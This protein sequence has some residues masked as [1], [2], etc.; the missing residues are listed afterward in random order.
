MGEALSEYEIH[1]IRHAVNTVR[2]RNNN[3][4]NDPDPLAPLQ[5]DF[6]FW[7]LVGPDRVVVVDTGMD[8][9][10]AAA[11][12]HRQTLSPPEALRALG[13]WPDAVETVILTHA[14]YDHVGYLHAFPRAE[15]WMQ[16]AEMDFVTGDWMRMPYFAHAYETD[17]I[18]ALQKLADADRL[19][20][21][22]REVD[23]APGISLHWVGGHTAGQEVVR[24]HTARGWVVLASDA[25]HYYEELERGVPFAIA[26]SLPDML[27][28]HDRLRE[29]AET[30][31]HIVPG[32][33][34]VVAR[35]YPPA[36]RDLAENVFRV[37]LPP[38]NLTL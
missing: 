31:A 17:E 32:H 33:D 30:D 11:R 2:V 5:M 13:I 9:S 34:P 7:V 4:I 35:I 25:I 36:R 26:F 16:E 21:H 18:A 8:P 20:L 29:L 38:R 1:A 6:H 28:A 24:V 27:A 19:H 23:L 14:H 12:G 10:K 22:G 3:F 37:D 15:F